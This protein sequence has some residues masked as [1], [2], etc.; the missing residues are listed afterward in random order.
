MPDSLIFDGADDRIVIGGLPASLGSGA[1]TILFIVKADV[2]NSYQQIQA[3]NAIDGGLM[4]NNNSPENLIAGPVTGN[5]GA[6][7]FGMTEFDW[8]LI[9]WGKAAGSVVAQF[10]KYVYATNVWTHSGRPEGTSATT[11]LRS[12]PCGSASRAPSQARASTT[13][14]S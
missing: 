7:Q 3:W 13:G 1:M 6:S 2:W 14:T 12:R 9:G 4:C 10:H 8:V 11:C 5:N